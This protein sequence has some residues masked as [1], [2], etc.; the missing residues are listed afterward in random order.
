MNRKMITGVMLA[1]SIVSGFAADRVQQHAQNES[2]SS[3]LF[4]GKDLSGWTAL[5][6]GHWE[7]KDGVIVGTSA[8]SEKRH[9]MLLSDKQYSNFEVKLE[10]K[11]LSGNSGFYFRTKR[12]K[13]HTVSVAGFQA[14]IDAS[15][16]N[17]GGLYET[18]G[19]KW[20][21]KPPAATKAFKPGEWNTMTV[22]AVGS[23]IVVHLNGIKTA[24]LKD[25]P[26]RLNGYFG[27]QLHG[28]QKM[29]V[30]F[31]NI[32]IKELK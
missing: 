10:Y 2:T 31:R 13:R 12:V 18:L 32:Q 7:V 27:L 4:N 3:A 5:P 15:G 20:V 1:L 29:D 6:G 8:K 30:A 25:D 14:E 11:A 9:G 16:S 22:R 17:A 19:R 26:G 24:E 28:G 23:H 21:V